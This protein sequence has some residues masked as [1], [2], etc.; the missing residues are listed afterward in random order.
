MIPRVIPL[1][2]DFSHASEYHQSYRH[3]EGKRYCP[4]V[5]SPNGRVKPHWVM[6]NHRQQKHQEAAYYLDWN[7]D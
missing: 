7:E 6:M 5:V 3:P 4:V 1:C 2:R